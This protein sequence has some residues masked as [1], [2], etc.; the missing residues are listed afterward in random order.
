MSIDLIDGQKHAAGFCTLA[1]I[2]EEDQRR[3]TELLDDL[4]GKLPNLPEDPHLLY[5][6]EVNSTEQVG[7]NKV[8]DP[9]EALARIKSEFR[10]QML[11]IEPGL[12]LPF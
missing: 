6:T 5:A 7:E 12:D 4:R 11:E 2:A 8:P 1:G 10:R 9:E 3:L